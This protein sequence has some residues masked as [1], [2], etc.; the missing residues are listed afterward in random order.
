MRTKQM[1]KPFLLKPV[2]KDYLWGGTRLRT[3]YGKQLT[4]EPLA[5]TWECA[6]H[7]NGTSIVAS[8]EN[9]GKRLTTVL[10]ENPSYLG[11]HA[12]AS[13]ALPILIKLIDAQQ[14]LSVQVHPDDAYARTHEQEQNGK[15]EMWYILDAEEGASL[16]YGFSRSIVPE[17]L[18][19]AL[20]NG[21][22]ERYLQKVPVKK[23][24]VFLIE[25]GTVHA[26]GAGIVLA[27]VQQNSNLTYRLYDYNRIDKDGRKRELHLKKAQEVIQFSVLDIPE[28]EN[29]RILEQTE[30]SKRELLC[31]C[32]YFQTEKLSLHGTVAWSQQET[33]GF[34][35]FLCT[36]GNACIAYA[37]EDLFSIAKGDCV[38]IPA[39]SI[40]FTIRGNAEILHVTC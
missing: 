32:P 29:R 17:Q 38:F 15:T 5:E 25:A 3:V 36:E 6:T 11:T 22:I 30:E 19:H 26:I 21:T 12:N 34:A 18:T 2:G 13:G 35:V 10:Q 40:D 31:C 24:D 28:Q 4:M 37:E 23:G 16:V 14:N 20:E 33:D 39:N 9:A 1:G 7:P 27:E 8:G